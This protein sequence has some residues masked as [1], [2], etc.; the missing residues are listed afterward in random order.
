MQY[1]GII[2]KPSPSSWSVEKLPCKKPILGAKKVKDCCSRVVN[3][4]QMA[5]STNYLNNLASQSEPG[6]RSQLSPRG[7]RSNVCFQSFF[8][9][10]LFQRGKPK[11]KSQ[12]RFILS[13]PFLKKL[14]PRHFQPASAETVISKSD[15]SAKRG[16]TNR[17]GVFIRQTFKWNLN[18][19]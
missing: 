7:V 18:K 1:T 3:S 11:V 19:A 6:L 12:Y 17:T 9:G 14:G 4:F 8:R 13:K 15:L 5:Y 2:S 16:L 10:Q